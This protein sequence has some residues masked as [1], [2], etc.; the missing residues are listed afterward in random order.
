MD[1]FAHSLPGCAETAWEP[2]AHHLSAVGRTAAGFASAFGG[3]AAAEA[4]GRL[5][6]IGKCSAAYQR[7]IRQA[8]GTQKG[9]DHSTGRLPRGGVDRNTSPSPFF[10]WQKIQNRRFCDR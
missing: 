9:P 3:E 1:L 5:H 6:D 2:L 7:Y 8:G 10:P 4:M